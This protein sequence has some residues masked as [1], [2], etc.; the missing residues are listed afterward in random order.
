MAPT[1]AL[2]FDRS[3]GSKRSVASWSRDKA[4]VLRVS[5]ER[6]ASLNLARRGPIIPPTRRHLGRSPS[7]PLERA[8]VP[9]C[10]VGRQRLR[11]AN[12]DETTAIA[13][14]R[15]RADTLG[16]CLHVLGTTLRVVLFLED[17]DRPSRISLLSLDAVL[18]VCAE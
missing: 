5:T 18:V 13:V 1:A 12:E 8:L 14:L 2:N 15:Q 3:H 9:A 4:T 10:L 17:L 16:H 7:E 6:P 11:E